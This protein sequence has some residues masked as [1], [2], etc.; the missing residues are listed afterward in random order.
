[1]RAGVGRRGVQEMG[2]DAAQAHELL[3]ERSPWRSLCLLLH[4][5]AQ[6][7]RGEGDEARDHLE[8]AAHLAAVSAPLVQALC[9]SQLALLFAGEDDLE[10][11]TVAAGR[12]R[13]QVVRCRLDDCPTSA[14]VFA[15]SAELS[16]HVGQTPEATADLRQALRLLSGIS[17]PSP[18]Y[19]VECHI[20]A[21]RTSL[22]LGGSVAAAEHLGEAT[23]VLRRT[24][25]ARVLRAWLENAV[26]RLDLV[27]GSADGAAWSL[28]AAE[29]RVLR[30]LPSHLSF[31]EIADRLYVSPN[32]VKTHAR[33]IYRKLCVSDR[34]SAVDR[35][36]AAGLVEAGPDTRG[37]DLGAW[38]IPLER[39]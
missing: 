15:V 14:L 10:R 17:D 5:V 34:G 16:A 28:T 12:A 32:T 18:W 29:L 9:L 30:Y 3:G 31:R 4:G 36:R 23:R 7:L 37:G 13:A 26:G 20:A 1:M 22:R 24:P 27:Q 8:R 25:D 33:G 19:E 21:G 35:A 38:S 39:S 2:A 6:H 11:G